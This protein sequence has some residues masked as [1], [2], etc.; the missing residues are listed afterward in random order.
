MKA[1]RKLLDS[2]AHLFEKGGKFE[3]F[4]ALYEAPDTLLFTPG[5]VTQGDVHVRDGLDLKR[6]MI[7]VV[8]ALLPCVAMALYNT[9][10]QANL[11]ISQ[12]ATPIDAWQIDLLL[13]LRVAPMR[14]STRRVSWPTWPTAPCGLCPSSR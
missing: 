5:H 10:F 4:E 13:I 9:G 8:A 1:L 11:A 14:P 7:T 3:K 2:Q 6:M 12:G